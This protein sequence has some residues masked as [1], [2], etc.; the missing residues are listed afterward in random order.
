MWASQDAALFGPF[1]YQLS[2]EVGY[3]KDVV[4]LDEI[5]IGAHLHRGFYVVRECTCRIEEYGNFFIE[6]ADG[7]AQPNAR[8]IGQ[9]VVHQHQIELLAF[10]QIDAVSSPLLT[11][12]TSNPS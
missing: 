6:L 11:L 3:V 9:S 12:V 10:E 4:R 1:F 8:S 2:D 5:I 7:H